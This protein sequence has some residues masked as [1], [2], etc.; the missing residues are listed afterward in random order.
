MK[1]KRDVKID[2]V[3]VDYIT[4]VT[5]GKVAA[6]DNLYTKGKFLAESDNTSIDLTILLSSEVVF[7]E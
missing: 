7:I 5:A 3:I 1:E 6:A 4:L 2:L